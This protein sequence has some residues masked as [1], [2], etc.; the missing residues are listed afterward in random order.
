VPL[1][2]RREDPYHRRGHRRGAA[3]GHRPRA[4]GLRLLRLAA[5][6]LV[7]FAVYAA[8]V[9]THA[10]ARSEYGGV[11]PH[12]LLVAESIVSDGDIDL[13]DEY[14]SGAYRSWHREPLAPS[15]RPM[16]SG[17]LHE[18]QGMGFGVLIAPA[19]AIG[20]PRAVELWLAA[21]AALGF[22][23]AALLARRIVPEPWASA[24][25]ALAG[26]SPPAVGLATAVSPELV[27]GMLL[28]GAAVCA[29]AVREQPRLLPAAGGATML[30]GLPWL[31]PMLVIPA[32][33]VAV[34]LV[35]WARHGRRR[36][37]SL[38]PLEILLGTLVFYA[39]LN[40]A[41]FG[42][43]TPD[44]TGSATGPSLVDRL[45]RLVGMWLDRDAGLLR[46]AP[47]LLLA[48]WAGWLLWRSRREGLSRVLPGQRESE[49][50][51][52]LAIAVC[53]AQV[54]AAVLALRG[55]DGPGF[56]GASFAAALPCAGALC[57]WGLR[58]ARR[59]GAVLGVLTLAA[60]AWL[61]VDVR[62]AG[63]S[64]DTP[65]NAPWG[66]L[67]SVFPRWDTGS[68]AEVLVTA[69]VGVAV[70]AL[71]LREWRLGRRAMMAA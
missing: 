49:A 46:W 19:Y 60:S 57:G 64:L 40:D 54:L 13:R 61:L 27:G 38:V 11:E 10:T 22:V 53:G 44:A 26:L 67:V 1:L 24:G 29:L 2:P 39:S 34:A 48:F 32:I 43:L 66:P 9:G 16:P 25:A 56:P 5:L 18:P 20:G 17:V 41:L 31:S 3:D 62:G 21:L 6:W 4:G 69:A 47:V 50:A 70:L 65:P 23:L 28:A 71:L 59:V 68:A 14:A 15:A 55:I 33:P 37:G 35:G 58:R 63:A 12:H 42:G 30:A 8:T 36:A 45:P 52:G 51:A 7:L